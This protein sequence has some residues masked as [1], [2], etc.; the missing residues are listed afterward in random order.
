MLLLQTPYVSIT[1]RELLVKGVTGVICWSKQLKCEW[2]Q[3]FRAQLSSR[4]T[5]LFT[6]KCFQISVLRFQAV[7]KHNSQKLPHSETIQL[8]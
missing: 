8:E 6:P 2:N 5:S 3:C 7:E 1:S 4:K